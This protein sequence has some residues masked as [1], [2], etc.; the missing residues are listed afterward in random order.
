MKMRIARFA[1][2]PDP[3]SEHLVILGIT[4]PE[5]FKPGRLYEVIEV[6]GEH[7]IK[8]VGESAAALERSGAAWSRDANSLIR[9][10]HHLHTKDE[11]LRRERIRSRDERWCQGCGHERHDGRE[12][13]QEDTNWTCTCRGAE[14]R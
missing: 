14:P 10:G 11:W 8:D 1:V 13:G 7:I 9:E 6:D 4:H 3:G 2:R 5:V 12:C